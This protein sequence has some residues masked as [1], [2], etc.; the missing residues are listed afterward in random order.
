MG[1][2]R[3]K[4]EFKIRILGGKLHKHIC[5]GNLSECL[6]E[7]VAIFKIQNWNIDVE[8]VL[9]FKL[10]PFQRKEVSSIQKS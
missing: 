2:G 10:A 7:E 8:Y 9:F 5:V 6:N 1:R 3:H 4:K